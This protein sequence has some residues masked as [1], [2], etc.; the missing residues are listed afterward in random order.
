M[1]IVPQVLQNYLLSVYVLQ[2]LKH[3]YGQIIFENLALDAYFEMSESD[4]EIDRSRN[5]GAKSC[6]SPLPTLFLTSGVVYQQLPSGMGPGRGV[7]R[8]F[9]LPNCPF[10]RRFSSKTLSTILGPIAPLP[11]IGSDAARPPITLP[12]R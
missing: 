7:K 2:I 3:R 8:N 11:T 9:P 12:Y 6:Q 10:L 4:I 5:T 1:I